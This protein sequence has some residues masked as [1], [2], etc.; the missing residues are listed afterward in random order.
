MK[1]FT[2]VELVISV[3]II[4]CLLTPFLFGRWCSYNT[5]LL[6]NQDKAISEKIDL[7]N[8]PFVLGC[9]SQLGLPYGIV[10]E[11]ICQAKGLK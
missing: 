4:G 11:I 6:I 8:W 10:T 7:P 9:F 2:L 3:L 1:G 5:E